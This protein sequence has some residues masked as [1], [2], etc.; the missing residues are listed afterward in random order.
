MLS[1]GGGGGG[2]DG[3]SAEPSEVAVVVDGVEMYR[4]NCDDSMCQSTSQKVEAHL[5]KM[6][7]TYETQERRRLNRAQAAS[8]STE[9]EEMTWKHRSLFQRKF[10]NNS[11]SNR[12]PILKRLPRAIPKSPSR[13]KEICNVQEKVKATRL[14]MTSWSLRG[15]KQGALAIKLI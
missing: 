11:F 14:S 7:T 5:K 9:S 4:E 3:G 12:L 2:A 10:E 6:T 8:M 13:H 15:R 1:G